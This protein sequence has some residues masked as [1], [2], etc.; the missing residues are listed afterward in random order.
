MPPYRLVGPFRFDMEAPLHKPVTT[1]TWASFSP[2]FRR[3]LTDR[4]T[5]T[6]P[7]EGSV[8]IQPAGALGA[9]QPF[10]GVQA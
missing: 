10:V 1:L 7:P 6:R 2:Q 4:S 8:Q 9:V 3:S 5:L